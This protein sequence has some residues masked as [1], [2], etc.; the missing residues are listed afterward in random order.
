MRIV[1]VL[2]VCVFMCVCDGVWCGCVCVCIYIY[3]YIVCVLQCASVI[4]FSDIF[5]SHLRSSVVRVL[6]V[7]REYDVQFAEFLSL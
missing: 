4:V 6:A 5:K 7:A 1:V 2:L 3:I